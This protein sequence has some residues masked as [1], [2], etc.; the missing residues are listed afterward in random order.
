VCVGDGWVGVGKWLWW[1][2][3]ELRGWWRNADADFGERGAYDRFG[4]SGADGVIYGDGYK[5][6]RR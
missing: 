1:R 5:R 6:Q 4:A 2:I 3:G